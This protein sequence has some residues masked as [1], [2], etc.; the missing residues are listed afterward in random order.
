MIW[1]RSFA[2]ATDSELIST[3]WQLSVFPISAF[4]FTL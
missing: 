4:F 2:V 3:S 1:G